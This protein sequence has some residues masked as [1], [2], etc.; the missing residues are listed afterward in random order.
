MWIEL[1]HAWHQT[2]VLI[3]LGVATIFL[4]WS[5]SLLE[6]SDIVTDYIVVEVPGSKCLT[7]VKF[8]PGPCTLITPACVVLVWDNH[9]FVYT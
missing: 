7:P 4:W 2:S 1:C 5:T 6:H 9:L 3:R 8:R